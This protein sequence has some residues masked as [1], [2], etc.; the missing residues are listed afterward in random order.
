MVLGIALNAQITLTRNV[1]IY[2]GVYANENIDNDW[3]YV[4]G[5]CSD[6]EL[7]PVLNYRMDGFVRRSFSDRTF[8]A[9]R[10]ISTMYF[11]PA[12]IKTVTFGPELGLVI[13]TGEAPIDIYGGFRLQG[14]IKDQARMF[15]TLGYDFRRGIVRGFD[16]IVWQLGF[17]RNFVYRVER[18]YE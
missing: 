4:A 16:G 15:L 12:H 5:I 11:H 18:I 10:F 9:G 17:G 3:A 13:N 6:F 8:W 1:T 2:T 14:G 7:T